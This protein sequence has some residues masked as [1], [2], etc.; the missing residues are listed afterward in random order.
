MIRIAY[1]IGISSLA[2]LQLHLIL[3]ITWHAFWQGGVMSS[4]FWNDRTGWW[5]G[6]G[7]I[8]LESRR[9]EGEGDEKV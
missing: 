2:L 9:S 8:R 6:V 5:V 7:K 4:H 3:S 1:T